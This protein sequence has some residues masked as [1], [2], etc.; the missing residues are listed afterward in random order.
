[1]SDDGWLTGTQ[2]LEIP[3]TERFATTLSFP[4]LAVT[5]A[6]I[7]QEGRPVAGARVRDL[8]RGTVILTGAD[9]SFGFAGVEPGTIALQARLRDQTSA[10]VRVEVEADRPPDPV[11]L[12]LGTGT[13]PR[14]EIT[15]VGADGGPAGG[16]FVFFEED[17]KGLRIVMTGADGRAAAGIEAPLPRRLRAAATT[18]TGWAFGGWVAWSEAQTGLALQIGGGGSLLIRSDE[19]RS[20]PQVA[21]QSGWDVSWLLRQLGTAP[22]AAPGQ[23]LRLI[24]LP[25]GRYTVSTATKALAVSL[26]DGDEAQLDLE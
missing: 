1:M 22:S 12:V 11:A 4:G 25:A 18:G 21:E 2:A 13:T 24:G 23:P 6:V 26:R 20:E 14:L 5:G 7:D 17:G 15:V 16:A 3:V 8:T 19:G 10:I 9:G